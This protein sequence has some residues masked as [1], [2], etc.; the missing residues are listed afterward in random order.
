LKQKRTA[1][2]EKLLQ[3]KN[4]KKY[5]HMSHNSVIMRHEL[6]GPHSTAGTKQHTKFS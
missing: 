3:K 1:I 2:K 5:K 4:T 6:V